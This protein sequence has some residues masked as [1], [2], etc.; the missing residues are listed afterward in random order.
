MRGVRLGAGRDAGTRGPLGPC[1]RCSPAAVRLP[2]GSASAALCGLCFRPWRS[3]GPR[4]LPGVG[5][6]GC[7]GRLRGLPRGSALCCSLARSACGPR[8][9]PAPRSRS[10]CS[11]DLSAPQVAPGCTVLP[12]VI[13]LLFPGPS[14]CFLPVLEMSH[15]G[16]TMF[17]SWGR[18]ELWMVIG[19][20]AL[21]ARLLPASRLLGLGHCELRARAA[22]SPPSAVL[23]SSLQLVCFCL[24]AACVPTATEPSRCAWR[25][26]CSGMLGW[27]LQLLPLQE[28]V[29]R[30]SS[31]HLE[32]L[33]VPPAMRPVGLTWQL[34][35]PF[36][37]RARWRQ[38]TRAL[39][40][41]LFLCPSPS[42]PSMAVSLEHKYTLGNK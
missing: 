30:S 10:D 36:P 35:A 3:P 41:P 34:P 1:R 28:L 13:A 7:S 12:E 22:A 32:H 26:L 17:C 2:R 29:L 5:L 19:N 38:E 4:L 23:F 42:L 20:A 8:H 18:A 33:L 9:C 27:G 40:P 39:F 37:V 6:P 15:T 24:G 31:Q 14:A 21:L 16:V 25:S 11:R